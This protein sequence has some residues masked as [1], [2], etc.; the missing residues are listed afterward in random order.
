MK[1]TVAKAK[2]ITQNWQNQFPNL[3]VYKPLHLL[4][5]CGPLLVGICLN[6]STSGDIYKPTFHCHCL[7]R[8][9]P[10]ISLSLAVQLKAS[11]GTDAGI[12]TRLE[13]AELTDVASKMKELALLPLDA[14][15]GVNEFDEACTRWLQQQQTP[16]WPSVIEDRVL[17]SAWAQKDYMRKLGDAEAELKSWPTFV[18][19]KIGGVTAWMARVEQATRNH[20]ELASV[21]ASEIDVHGVANLP[22]CE[23]AI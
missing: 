23:L 18:T 4:R 2:A 1:I 22:S 7:L 20:N 9:F 14:N 5:R 10:T 19:N 13:E 17:L 12:S 16:Y 11:N 21:L 6:R 15:F 3:G 8:K